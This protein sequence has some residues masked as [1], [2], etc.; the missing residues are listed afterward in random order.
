M[1]SLLP[2]HTFPFLF[3]PESFFHWW[4]AKTFLINVLAVSNV[5]DICLCSDLSNMWHRSGV[6]VPGRH[7][8]R[9]LCRLFTM[10]KVIRDNSLLVFSEKRCRTLQ[11]VSIC[12]S[13]SLP[14]WISASVCSPCVEC[15][16][17]SASYSCILNRTVT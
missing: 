8:K 12:L 4:L 7:E 10:N 14:L 11:A 2:T 16:C 6:C 13:G 15:V 5:P 1:R 9:F 17:A 3:V